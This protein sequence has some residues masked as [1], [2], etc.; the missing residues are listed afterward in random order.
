[1]Q[2]QM[3]TPAVENCRPCRLHDREARPEFSTT[4]IS[5]HLRPRRIQPWTQPRSPIVRRSPLFLDP[6]LVIFAASD[7]IVSNPKPKPEARLGYG[8]HHCRISLFHMPSDSTPNLKQLSQPTLKPET[9][10]H[11]SNRPHTPLLDLDLAET[12]PQIASPPGR[13][14]NSRISA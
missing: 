6:S 8:P 5:H 11:E 10:F 2:T 1:M 7:L 14:L 12:T 3:S 13:Q 4:S 9:L